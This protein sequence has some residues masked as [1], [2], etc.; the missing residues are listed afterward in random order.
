MTLSLLSRLIT[1]PVHKVKTTLKW[2]EIGGSFDGGQAFT[3]FR[4]VTPCSPVCLTPF[5]KKLMPS[6]DLHSSEMLR[7]VNL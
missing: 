4:D 3:V 5:K 7:S 2:K 1:L 6:C